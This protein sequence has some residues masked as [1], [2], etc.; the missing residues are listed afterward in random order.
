MRK[1]LKLFESEAAYTSYKEAGDVWLPRVAFIPT[2]PTPIEQ[3]T[4]D[5]PGRLVYHQQ[6]EHFIEI[7]NG[8]QM[9]FYDKYD[10]DNDEWYR[11]TVDEHGVI[12]IECPV[13]KVTYDD[14]GVLNF[15]N[16]P[17]D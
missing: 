9:M 16:Y 11:A 8:G 5:T 10:A 3:I 2:T 15:V 4:T 14:N 6:G 12:N 1:H 13:D 7:C 17:C